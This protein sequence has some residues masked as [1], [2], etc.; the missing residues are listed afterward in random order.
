MT[1]NQ[2]ELIFCSNIDESK[3]HDLE[4]SITQGNPQT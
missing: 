2:K 4:V 1:V 3:I